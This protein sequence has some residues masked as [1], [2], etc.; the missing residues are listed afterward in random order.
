MT[1]DGVGERKFETGV[2][3]VALFVQNANG[4]YGNGVPWNG[5]T[6]INVN[7]TG[8]EPNDLWADN[9]KYATMLS[10]EEC[11]GSIEC[12]DYP[13]EFYACDGCEDVSGAIIDLQSRSAFGLAFRTKIGNDTMGADY[14]YKL[15][16]LYGCLA[17]PPE[18]SFETV[19]DSPDA[20]PLS[21][22]FKSTAANATGH[23]PV[24]HIVISSIDSPEK[25]AAIEALVHA[26][27]GATLPS[28][29][30]VFSTNS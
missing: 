21:F 7:H 16:L 4:T 18:R 15:H 30:T 23:R 9:I 6:S 2:D 1:W 22:D 5:V 10:A 29:D 17:S 8:G 3:H 12:Y 19:N 14:G 24:S 20:A 27:T 28:P 26:A 13:E 25:Y 11:E